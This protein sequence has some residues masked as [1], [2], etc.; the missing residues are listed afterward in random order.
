MDGDNLFRQNPLLRL[1]LPFMAGIVAGW[2]CDFDVLHVV[3]LFAFSLV[4]LIVGM[5]RGVARNMYGVAAMVAMFSLGVFAENREYAAKEPEW[6]GEKQYFTA[7]L[8][9]VPEFRGTSVKV[10]ADVSVPDT[11]D[12][13]DS[14]RSGSV[15]LYFQRSV[16]SD[17]LEIGDV[18]TAE[19]V[20]APPQNAGNPAEFDI[21]SHYYIKNI[22][23]TAYLSDGVWQVS[24]QGPFSLS[25]YALALREKVI[26]RYRGLGVEGDGLALLSALTVGERRDLSQEI[27]EN[28][29]VAGA[30]H[31]LALS[32]LH[33][34]I[35]YAFLLLI[36]PLYTRRPLF[37][38]TREV[39]VVLLLWAFA[40]VAGLTPSVV[41]AA[42]LFTLVSVGRCL[43][44]DSSS[45]S[46]LS[47]AA[48]VMLI[49]S[50]HLLFD[51]SF[52][53]SFA[54]VFSILLL[55]PPMQRLFKVDEH[56]RL[57]GYIVN[58]FIVSLAA[59]LG[60][61]PFVW[62]YFG[63]F[64]LYFLLTNLLVIPLAFC[65][66]VLSL[67]ALLL[68][69]IPSL[70]G[71]ASFSLDFVASSMN[72]SV[73]FIASLPGASLSLPSI[74]VVAACGVAVLLLLGYVALVKKNRWLLVLFLAGVVSFVAVGVMGRDDDFQGD[75]LLI[76][77]NKRNPL[78]HAVTTAGDNW[79]VSTVP[80]FDAEYEYVSMPYIKR[81]GL[82]EPQW[83]CWNYGSQ[84]LS[85][86]EGLLCFNGLR[87]RL[88]DNAYWNESDYACPA[89]IVV[90]CRGFLGSVRELLE[91]Y[92]TSCLVL[93]AS[94]YKH[95]RERIVREAV[96]LGVEPVDISRT[97]AVMI[98]NG[99][100]G[101]TLEPVRGK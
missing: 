70:Q 92:P 39:V 21:E 29:S 58:L 81:E 17:T 66:I 95:S 96:V 82:P 25:M 37:F 64:P 38:V 63:V 55:L 43:K 42:I 77:N 13:G 50:P 53:L 10:L 28:Y 84:Q 8:V 19:A 44:Q 3:A 36:M 62:H 67:F 71:V 9:G 12:M 69:L 101:F 97:G 30:S 99:D 91:V 31:I 88:V 27:K 40:F 65:V 54:A 14:R 100:D 60:T 78:L 87:V 47:F 59:Q 56:G 86:E 93:D 98:K 11:V 49:Y 90:L 34:G 74:G 18:L 33:I 23:G 4:A 72:S 20:I 75:R 35:I 76:Y 15:Y 46:S 26:A 16:E 89:D 24:G 68:S 6:S 45:V 7:R 94:L 61:L 57:Y 51:I 41:R 52:Q 85:V 5:Q 73:T 83:A 2:Q 32:G 80:Q 79:L 22:S 1:V 48:L